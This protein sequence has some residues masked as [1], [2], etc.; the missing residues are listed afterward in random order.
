MDMSNMDVP[1]VTSRTCCSVIVGNKTSQLSEHVR[2]QIV[3]LSKEEVSH[4]QSASSG[5]PKVIT[6]SEDQYIKLC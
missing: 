1:Q 5:R 2:S 4:C 3:T 6:P